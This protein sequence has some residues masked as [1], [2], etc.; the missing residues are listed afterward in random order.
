MNQ[1]KDFLKK[2]WDYKSKLIDGI[3]EKLLKDTYKLAGIIHKKWNLVIKYSCVGMVVVRQ[4][5][6]TLP[7]IY[8]MGF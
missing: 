7:T 5:Q 8:I 4:M 1:E 2:G 6:Y 3:D